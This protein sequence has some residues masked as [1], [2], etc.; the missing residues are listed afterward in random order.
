M[1]YK[2]LNKYTSAYLNNILIYSKTKKEHIYHVHKVLSALLKAGLHININKYKFYTIE[3]RY[4]SLIISTNSIKMDP[5]KI[6][7]IIK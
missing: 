1:L 3:T 2:S 6:K 7:A 4:L 5:A